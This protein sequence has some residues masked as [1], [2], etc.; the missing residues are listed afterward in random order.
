MKSFKIILFAIILIGFNSFSQKNDKQFQ[1]RT[2]AF[3]NLENLFDTIND[4][5]KLDERSPIMD[6][7]AKNR[8]KAYWAKIDNMAKVISEIGVEKSKT[9]PAII[10][11]C[12]IENRAVLEDLIAHDKLKKKHYGIIH[13]E[14]P[15]ERGID[16][17]LLYQKRY[18]KP[19][20]HKS[21][22]LEILDHKGKKND[23]RDQLLV[24]GML[25]GEIIHLIVNHW[26]SRSG[27]EQRSRPG[28]EKAAALNVKIIEDLQEQYPNPKVIIMGDL[29]DDP[30]NTSVKKVLGAKS[31]K[32]GLKDGDIYNPMDDMHRRGLSTLSYR[33][34]INLFDQIMLTSPFITTDNDYSSYKFF[35]ANIFNPRYL[36]NKKG[37]WKGYSFRSWS[38]GSFTGGYSDHYP[39]YVYLIKEKK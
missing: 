27:G 9:S 20:D 26:P 15:D 2:V 18:F 23:T 13:Y 5:T 39:V 34:N 28:R 37:R 17:A 38:N 36:T 21:Y 33:D 3:Y 35:K 31:K 1:I 4:P 30:T 22:T 10:G 8:A 11:V 32:T 14:S 29:N 16:V 12:E 24:T 19:M 6:M 7:K 25:D